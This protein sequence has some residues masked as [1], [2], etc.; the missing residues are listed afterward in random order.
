MKVTSIAIFVLLLATPAVPMGLDVSSITPNLW[1]PE[2]QTTNDVVTKS[3][4]IDK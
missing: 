4:P 2:T 3:A 1:F